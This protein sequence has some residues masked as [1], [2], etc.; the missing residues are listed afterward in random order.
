MS[1]YPRLESR[2]S[3]QE[4]R[5]LVLDARVEEL[6]EDVTASFKQIDTRF[7]QVDARVT[8]LSRDMSASFKQLVE[9]HIQQE[10]QID[11]R[12]NQVDARLDKIENRLDRVEKDVADIKGDIVDIKASMATKED[13]AG[14]ASKEDLAALENRILD[15]F[16]QLIAT[17][18]PQRP[19][20]E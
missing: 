3:A 8:E 17:V 11:T 12:F 2:V 14:M 19:P 18:N 4:R 7:N 9:Y 13:L 16:K 5:Q 1:T 6:A 10:N 20:S 15:A